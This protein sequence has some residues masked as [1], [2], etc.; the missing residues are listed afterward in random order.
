M[1]NKCWPTLEIFQQA[2]TVSYNASRLDLLKSGSLI[3]SLDVFA[4]AF[5]IYP[6]G[7]LININKFILKRLSI[8]KRVFSAKIQ[9]TNVT[10]ARELQH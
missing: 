6:K 4:I 10:L 7:P 5:R 1:S 8:T 3:W 9:C 2:S